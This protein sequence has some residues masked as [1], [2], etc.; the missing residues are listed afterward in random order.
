VIEQGK[1]KQAEREKSKREEDEKG[2][3]KSEKKSHMAFIRSFIHRYA[4][5]FRRRLSL[6][7]SL[8]HTHVSRK[9]PTHPHKSHHKTRIR[10]TT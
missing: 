10:H 8:Q 9:E 4:L 1:S 3:Q 5:K 7:L 6:S 2:E